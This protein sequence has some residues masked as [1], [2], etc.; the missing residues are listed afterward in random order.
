MRDM[1]P[2]RELTTILRLDVRVYVPV[3]PGTNLRIR[4]SPVASNDL[5]VGNE[6][7]PHY[8]VAEPLPGSWVSVQ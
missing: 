1:E 2:E 5:R 4:A 6:H 3:Y 7:R 8:S